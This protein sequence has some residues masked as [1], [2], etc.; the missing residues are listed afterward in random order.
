MKVK[1]IT[2]KCGCV[3]IVKTS[4][5]FGFKSTEWIRKR[6]CLFHY[7]KKHKQYIHLEPLF[8]MRD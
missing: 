7:L 3:Y 5:D 6:V 1:E 4:H 8:N 2:F